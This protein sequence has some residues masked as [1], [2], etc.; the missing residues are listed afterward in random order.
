LWS[1]RADR[2]SELRGRAAATTD[3]RPGKHVEMFLI[4]G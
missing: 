1:G 4:G 3:G 2:Y